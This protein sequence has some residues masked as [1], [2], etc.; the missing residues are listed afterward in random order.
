MLK[1]LVIEDQPAVR[2]I[3]SEVIQGM[4]IKMDI[5]QSSSLKEAEVALHE[6]SWD[7]VVTDLSLGD[8]NSLDL[9]STLQQKHITLPPIVL[10]SGFLTDKH[11]QQAKSL[12]IEHILA[13]PFDP[14]VLLGCVQDVLDLKNIIKVPATSNNHAHDSKLLPEMF[15]MDRKLGL[16]FR[17]FDEMPKSPDV[18]SVCDSALKIAIDMV[19]AQGGYLALYE[20]NKETLVQVAFQ[21]S[22]S[23]NPIAK[24]C[25][26]HDTPFAPLIHASQEFIEVLPQQQVKPCWPDIES[27]AYLA[28]PVYLQG[29][30]MGVLCLT[31]RLNTSPLTDESRYMLSLLIKKLDTL[32]DNR[33]VHAALA[34][35][36]NETL[37]ALVRSLEA[38]DR[39]TKDHSSRVSLLSVQFARALGLDDESVQLIKTGGLLHDI[40]KVGIADSV[41]LKPGRYTDQEYNIMKAHPAIG[42]S[43]LKNMDTLVRER[44]IVRHH[45]ERWDGK[46]YPDK[47]G[48]TEIPFEARIVCVADAIDAMTTHR[49]Y[50]Q[51]KPLSFCAE[52]LEF[53]SG[54]QFDPQVVAVA[55]EAI[56]QGNIFT[57]AKSDNCDEGVMPIQASMGQDKSI[58]QQELPYA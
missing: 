11:V 39:Y 49:V 38:R 36:M 3:I 48:S 26:L 31:N 18:S 46:G 27:N 42:D 5:G 23:P 25:H 8:G 10:I 15:E 51:A 47:I 40:G 28:I 13:K 56:R 17:M 41:L 30:P 33:A 50:R 21:G 29:I 53:A 57:Q 9:I 19:H 22:N 55:L 43:I 1:I 52:Q 45:H 24:T 7:M 20:R 54:S 35:S 4:H 14:D 58:K 44:L 32:L 34:D 2:E 6:Q 12:N 16:L 37:I